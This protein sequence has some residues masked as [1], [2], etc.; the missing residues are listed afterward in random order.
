[1]KRKGLFVLQYTTNTY[2]IQKALFFAR[3]SNI[4]E[5]TVLN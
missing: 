5:N 2:F 1:M 4:V 3:K